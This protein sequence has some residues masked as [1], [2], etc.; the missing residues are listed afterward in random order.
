LFYVFS[1]LFWFV[2]DPQA[3]GVLLVVLAALLALLGRRRLSLAALP[4]AV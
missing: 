4:P 3:L 2:A 1:K